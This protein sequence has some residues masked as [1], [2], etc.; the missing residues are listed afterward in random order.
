MPELTTAAYGAEFCISTQSDYVLGFINGGDSTPDQTDA[1]FDALFD[2]LRE[3]VDARLPEG[4]SWQPRTADFLHQV[5]TPVPDEQEMREIFQEAWA[6]VESRFDSIERQI[7]GTLPDSVDEL[8]V[9][10]R[11]IGSPVHRARV[12][13]MLVDAGMRQMAARVRQEAIYAATR[14]RSAQEVAE[15]LS[16][17]QAAIKKAITKAISEHNRR[18]LP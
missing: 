7:F 17:G 15:L 1:L 6:A 14:E 9:A 10:L 18:V 3:E 16:T 12:A 4:V 11:A 2:A 5:G 13:G 8:E